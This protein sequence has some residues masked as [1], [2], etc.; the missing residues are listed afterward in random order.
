MLKYTSEKNQSEFS[1]ISG[2]LIF[3][4]AL[5]KMFIATVTENFKTVCLGIKNLSGSSVFRCAVIYL[6]HLLSRYLGYW[7][8]CFTEFK[9]VQKIYIERH[10]L[11]NSWVMQMCQFNK[12]KNLI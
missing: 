1:N 7:L 6:F 2:G 4:K 11:K 5:K 9:N 3:V 10:S 12:R 8:F